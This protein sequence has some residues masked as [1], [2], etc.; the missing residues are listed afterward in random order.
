VQAFFS[1]LAFPSTLPADYKLN[2]EEL[3]A[4][5]VKL[6]KLFKKWTPLL[7]KFAEQSDDQASIVEGLEQACAARSHTHV[8]FPH[9]LKFLIENE[10]AEK[11]GV[12]LWEETRLNADTKAPFLSDKGV[13]A[14]LG[15]LKAASDDE[16]DEED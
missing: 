4:A 6:G 12:L 8:L 11:K 3:K 7:S 15:Q 9:G 14:I 5:V 2:R 1:L 16:D 10:V 13:Q